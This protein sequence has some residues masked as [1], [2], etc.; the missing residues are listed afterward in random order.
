MAAELCAKRPSRTPRAG[1]FLVAALAPLV[2]TV[3]V[4][5]CLRNR[6]GFLPGKLVPVVANVAREEKLN[7]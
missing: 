6:F 5:L 7:E 4:Q 2:S 1:R 3:L